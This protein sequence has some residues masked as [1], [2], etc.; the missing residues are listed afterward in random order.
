MVAIWPGLDARDIRFYAHGRQGLYAQLAAAL[1]RRVKSTQVVGGMG[2]Y[3]E[4]CKSRH[5]DS[6]DIRSVI[7]PGILQ[8]LDL[9][10][11]RAGR[12][13]GNR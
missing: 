12:K 5:Y 13:P 2:S 8:H 9:P 11:V 1:D 3:A 10:D 4:W 7:L 6:H